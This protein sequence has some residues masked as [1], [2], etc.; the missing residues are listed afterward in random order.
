M[1][2]YSALSPS[3]GPC[4]TL[5]GLPAGPSP[6]HSLWQGRAC[7]RPDHHPCGS[8]ASLHLP[9]RGNAK[10]KRYEAKRLRICQLF[11]APA[12]L[13]KRR[14]LAC[15]IVLGAL[16]SS[17]QPEPREATSTEGAECGEQAGGRRKKTARRR[18]SP[19]V[20]KAMSTSKL[21]RSGPA[22]SAYFDGTRG[23][24]A[25]GPAA[26]HRSSRAPLPATREEQG[27]ASFRAI[28][29]ACSCR[30]SVR[31]YLSA[32]EQSDLAKVVLR[33]ALYP[34]APVRPVGRLHKPGR[35][36]PAHRGQLLCTDEFSSN[37]FHVYKW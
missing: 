9:K 26:E 32:R 4:V 16:V 7:K 31:A 8:P 25:A 36:G 28:S 14:A 13:P 22:S 34:G 18:A 30:R 37:R 6:A 35:R 21:S 33:T 29:V 27:K 11:T 2:F 12:A 1:S 20:R 23:R 19:C 10:R 3:E 5:T 24:Q 17:L 15:L